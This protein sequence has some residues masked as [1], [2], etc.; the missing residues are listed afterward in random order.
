MLTKT[1]FKI[2]GSAMVFSPLV[3]VASCSSSTDNKVE[4]VVEKDIKVATFN[5][6]FATD[7]DSNETYKRWFDYLSINRMEQDRLVKK[8]KD[9][10]EMEP[11]ERVLAE[12]V[13]QVR[14]IAA[15]IQKN[16]PDVIVLN[17]FNNEGNGENKQI[18]KLF[19]DNF[20]SFGQS[21][22]SIDGGEELQPIIYPFYETYATNTGLKSHMDLDNDG[23]IGDNPEDAYGFGYYHGHYAFGVMSKYEID[24]QNTRTFQEFKWKDMPN[25][26]I[27]KIIV[28]NG[29][30]PAGMA[31]GDDW[32][33][34]EEWDNLR[35]SSKNH[36]DVPIN[37][38]FGNETQNIHLLISHP[39]PPSFELGGTNV[40]L[41]RNLAEVQFWREYIDN[42]SVIYDDKGKIGGIDGTKEKFIILGDL[43]ADNLHGNTST[44]DTGMQSL[45][46]SNHL[47]HSVINGSLLPT[48]IG[49]AAENNQYNHP[50]P[51]TRT[52]VFG[53]RVDWALPSV[54]LNTID[55]GVYWQAEG[56]EGRLLFNDIRI[57]KWGNSK[58]ISSDHRFVWVTI[59]LQS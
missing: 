54:N 37:I 2:L 14:N 52:S 34:Q 56:E 1:I 43:N 16:K 40:N 21:M 31:V 41:E 20:L 50:K 9:G 11:T 55:S 53:L 51:E 12:R 26:K 58:E 46:K 18:M 48:S 25:A 24:K 36:V 8:I 29:K 6:S 27:P 4:E 45:I 23:I 13:V 38:K 17:E 39:T 33:T 47:N 3:V 44:R 28:D 19:Q 22:N 59:R 15:I 49:G 7:G 35:L 10:I 57:G 30:I 5:I 32:Y 42:N